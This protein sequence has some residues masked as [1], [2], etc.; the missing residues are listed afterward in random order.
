MIIVLKMCA[1]SVK[2]E[3]EEELCQKEENERQRLALD[4]VF[5]Q[6]EDA[7]HTGL[8]AYFTPSPMTLERAFE[9]INFIFFVI[10]HTHI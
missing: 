10:A 1:K 4:V 2:E 6:P 8:C 5:K 3:Y 9:N 7:F